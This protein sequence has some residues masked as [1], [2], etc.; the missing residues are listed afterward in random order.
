MSIE[1][2]TLRNLREILILVL[3][4][5]LVISEALN[6]WL[7]LPLSLAAFPGWTLDM[8]NYLALLQDCIL[9]SEGAAWAAVPFGSWLIFLP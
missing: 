1:L 8:V 5:F 3:F 6:L 7:H 2:L 9:F 4:Y